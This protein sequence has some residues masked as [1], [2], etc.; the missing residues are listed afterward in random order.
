[1]SRINILAILVLI[2]T[3]LSAQDKATNSGDLHFL[4]AAPSARGNELSTLTTIPSSCVIKNI[5]FHSSLNRSHGGRLDE[6]KFK[7]LIDTAKP[8]DAH[9]P[10][11]RAWHYAPWYRGSFVVK[12]ETYHFTL[13]LGGLGTLITPKR[14]KGAFRFEHVPQDDQDTEMT[15]AAGQADDKDVRNP[16]VAPKPSLVEDASSVP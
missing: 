6:R 7:I 3:S 9:D 10:T 2:P 11:I 14:Q 13:Y 12:D 15:Q 4:Y 16:V 1:M 5:K 8:V